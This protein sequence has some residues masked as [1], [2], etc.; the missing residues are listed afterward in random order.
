MR[1]KNHVLCQ[2]QAILS[3][4]LYNVSGL[5]GEIGTVKFPKFIRSTGIA[6]EGDIVAAGRKL[7]FVKTEFDLSSVDTL[8]DVNNYDITHQLLRAKKLIP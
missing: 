5:K 7:F 3:Y 4:I 8:P 2:K 1:T 6:R